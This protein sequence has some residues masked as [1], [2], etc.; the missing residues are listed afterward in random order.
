[1]NP[2]IYE[3]TDINTSMKKVASDIWKRDA[4]KKT[5]CDNKGINL[6]TIW[7]HDWI[8]N[9]EEIKQNLLAIFNNRSIMK[10]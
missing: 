1:M 4:E 7:E 3:S 10:I 8:E 5:M 6:L 2:E 9:K